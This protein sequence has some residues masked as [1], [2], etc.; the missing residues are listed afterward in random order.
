MMVLPKPIFCPAPITIRSAK[1]FRGMPPVDTIEEDFKT[2]FYATKEGIG[3]YLSDT[4]W[5]PAS[6]E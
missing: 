3:Y 2:Y 6:Y 4:A 5:Q 1:N